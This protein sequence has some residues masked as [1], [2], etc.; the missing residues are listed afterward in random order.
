MIGPAAVPLAVRVALAPAADHP[1]AAILA[2]A[3]LAV[4]L[5]LL[6]WPVAEHA[7]TFTH[8]GGHAVGA[9]LMGGGVRH[10]RL[11]LDRTGETVSD[12][13]GALTATVV[14]LAGY[15]APPAFGLAGA[16]VLAHGG[17]AAVLWV[18]LA[19]L[20][21]ELVVVGNW[22]GRLVVVLAGGLFLVTLLRAP[23]AVQLV[24]ASTWVW[25]LLI[26]GL[27]DVLRTGRRGAD[28]AL[29]RRRTLVPAA[30]WAF[31]FLVWAGAALI[32]GGMILVGATPPPI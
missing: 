14:L 22:F 5:T 17:A 8:E 10:M 23:P 16:I 29:L 12:G 19:L 25:F 4:A 7:I 30:F 11:N 27:A 18:S 32:W 13:L 26:G 6:L 20:A 1:D 21:L 2:G 31:L 28:H 3:V 15:L 24:V 9:L